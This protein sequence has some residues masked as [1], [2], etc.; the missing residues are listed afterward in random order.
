MMSIKTSVVCAILFLVAV[1]ASAEQVVSVSVRGARVVDETLIVRTFGLWEGDELSGTAIQDGIRS[2]YGLGL[3]EDVSVEV[4]RTPIGMEVVVV[5][6][7]YPRVGVIEISGNDK[8]SRSDIIGQ[9]TLASGA[10]AAPAGVKAD[11]E[12]IRSLY[13]EKGYLLATVSSEVVPIEGEEAVVLRVVIDEGRRV[14][15]RSIV[16]EGNTRPYTDFRLRSKMKTKQDSFWRSGKFERDRYLDDLDRVIEF[17]REEGFLEAEIVSDSIAYDST[18]QYMDIFITVHQGDRYRVGDISFQDNVVRDTSVLTRAVHLTPETIY[19]KKDADRTIEDLYAL[20]AED[21]YIYLNVDDRLDLHDRVVDVRYVLDEGPQAHVRRVLI[22]GNL[23]TQD[24]VIRRELDIY[25]GQVFRRSALVHSQRDVFYLD[26]FADVMPNFEVLDN[27]DVD[28]IFDVEEKPVGQA[29]FGM[30]YSQN[31]KFTGNLGLTIPNF[32]G[33]GQTVSFAYE[34]GSSRNSMSFSF[35]EPWA[36]GRPISFGFSMYQVIDRSYS[37]YDEEKQ[38]ISF[39]L[40]RRLRWPDRYFRVFVGWRAEDVRYYNFSEAYEESDIPDEYNLAKMSWPRR[41]SAGTFVIARDS[42]NYPLFATS[43][44][45][46]A[47]NL[48]LAGGP[49]GGSVRHYKAVFDWSWYQATK[50]E[51]AFILRGRIGHIDGLSNPSEVLYSERFFP[52]GTDPDGMVRGYDDR[53]LVPYSAAG[54]REGGRAMLVL[55]LEYQVPVIERQLYLILFA[56]AGDSWRRWGEAE[57]TNLHRG[58]GFG[59]RFVAP[60]IGVIGLDMGYALDDPERGTWHTHFQFG[61]GF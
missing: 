58:I 32:R 7:E 27:G 5:V 54:F 56:D 53:A 8:V 48:E 4:D 34:F 52:G 43:G 12:R 59:G 3:F 11:I 19:A 21:G 17:Y 60:L 28:L 50:W 30:S 46:H 26:Y 33:S 25:P 40:G 18:L 44:S 45:Y 47:L 1:S 42:R 29:Q 14:K 6:L 41:T 22:E 57:L 24:A 35:E 20:Y 23:K 31:S 61:T 2:V 15:V 13:E 36:F 37:Y 9:M 49:F 51:Q 16:F 38:G 55:N 39:R 10:I